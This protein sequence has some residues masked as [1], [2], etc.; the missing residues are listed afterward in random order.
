LFF[1]TAKLFYNFESALLI[2]FSLLY[3]GVKYEHV[4]L[5]ELLQLLMCLSMD[6]GW[7][8]ESSRAFKMGFQLFMSCVCL[9]LARFFSDA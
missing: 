9:R 3:G 8:M 4:V 6:Y 7:N 5:L 1:I 2:T